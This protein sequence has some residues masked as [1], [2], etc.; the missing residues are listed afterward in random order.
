MELLSPVER[1]AT[2][3]RISYAQNMED[4]LLDRLFRGRPG[5]FV[6]VGAN[7]PFI[8]NNTYF[9]YLRGW[10]GVNVE[11]TPRGHALFVEHRPADLNLAVAA[12][13]DEGELPF[14]EVDGDEGL[15]GLSTL[16]A[17]MAEEH[18]AAGYRVAERRVPVRT[19]AGL[20]E[21]HSIAPPDLLSIDV[22]GNEAAVLRGVPWASWRPKVLVVEA[23]APL[24]EAASY[25]SWEPLLLSNGYLFAAFNGVNRFYLRDDLRDKLG[26]FET[27][28]NALD[29]YL[30]QEVVAIQQRCD[31]L[32]DRIERE[33]ADRR[34]ERDQF[35]QVRE[36]WEWAR[37]QAQYV[38]AIWEQECANMAK[39]RASYQ[40]ALAYFERAEA[41]FKEG[42][43][44]WEQD[45]EAFIRER[46]RFER[47]RAEW[48]AERAHHQDQAAEAQARL[49]PYLLLDRLRVVPAGYGLAR[50]VKRKLAS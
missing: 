32:R 30:R 48:Q 6:D 33:Q 1:P 2:P 24:S 4:I 47:E 3:A 13:D 27:P 38:Q 49:R 34:F 35:N 18:R 20:V 23:T 25:R 45:R 14:F 44:A 21:E 41:H 16:S 7:H 17:A 37:Q 9:F 12:S 42:Q 40:E 39:E 19:V 28:V 46:E 15:S 8:D 22:E 31:E 11:P 29:H 43:A 26:L 10:R 50:R 5:T 36:G